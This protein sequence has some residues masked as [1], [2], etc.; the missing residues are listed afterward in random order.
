MSVSILSARS[1]LHETRM[2]SNVLPAAAAAVSLPHLL[3]ETCRCP[4]AVAA[5]PLSSQLPPASSTSDWHQPVH[6]RTLAFGDIHGDA[7]Y[8]FVKDENSVHCAQALHP[9]AHNLQVQRPIS[10]AAS[11][12]GCTMMQTILACQQNS[13]DMYDK[14]IKSRIVGETERCTVSSHAQLLSFCLGSGGPVQ[15]WRR[16]LVPLQLWDSRTPLSTCPTPCPYQDACALH[17]CS[18]HQVMTV[19]IHISQIDMK[20]PSNPC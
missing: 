1:F 11:C 2:Y 10:F 9:A 12:C 13:W 6:T 5:C 8:Q 19:E 14:D 7:P 4:T 18:S 17:T 16:P 20:S 15:R 3:P